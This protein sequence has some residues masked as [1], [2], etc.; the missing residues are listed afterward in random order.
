MGESI[1]LTFKVKL[2]TEEPAELMQ[3][4]RS[5]SFEAALLADV[6][7]AVRDYLAGE[8]VESRLIKI[9]LKTPQFNGD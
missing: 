4:L 8:K 5:H 1:T 3:Q 6:A 7:D 2:Q 9:E